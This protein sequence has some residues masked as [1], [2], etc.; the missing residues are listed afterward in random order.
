MKFLSFAGLLMLVSCATPVKHK[1]AERV[2]RKTA[3]TPVAVEERTWVTQRNSFF[4]ATGSRI[5]AI[6][7]D[8]QKMENTPA[9]GNVA[10]KN[11]AYQS[12]SETRDLL[13]EVRVGL[14]KLRKVSE[15]DWSMKKEDFV[16]SMNDLEAKYELVKKFYTEQ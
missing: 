7:T 14:A 2:D 6:D 11:L 16:A 12:I 13:E 8:I 5:N 10:R 3:E 4:T 1:E 9:Q 15:K